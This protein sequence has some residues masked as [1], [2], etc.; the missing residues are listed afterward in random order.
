MYVHQLRRARQR[1]CA[2]ICILFK[3]N[4]SCVI[5]RDESFVHARFKGPT[6]P[7]PLELIGT[8][9]VLL[10]NEALVPHNEW[11]Y[12]KTTYLA[13]TNQQ[14]ILSQWFRFFTTFGSRPVGTSSIGLTTR[15]C[16][17]RDEVR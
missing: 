8:Q 5:A 6:T 11:R 15:T 12:V 3:L 13:C 9:V 4:A 1:H 10:G 17:L 16:R 7:P 14:R 2:V